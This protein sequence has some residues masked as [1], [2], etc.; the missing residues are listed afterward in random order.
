MERSEKRSSHEGRQGVGNV[1][2]SQVPLGETCG[3]FAGG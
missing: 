1:V 3:D 2:G